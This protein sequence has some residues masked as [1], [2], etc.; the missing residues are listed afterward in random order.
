MADFAKAIAISACTIYMQDY[1]GP[2]GMRLITS[3]RIEV[4][5]II[6]QNVVM[7]EEGLPDTT[8]DEYAALA[9]PGKSRIQVDLLKDY[10]AKVV[11][12]PS[13]QYWLQKHRPRMLVICGK[14]DLSFTV[15]EALASKRDF[16]FSELELLNAGHLALDEAAPQ[17][18]EKIRGFLK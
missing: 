18:V 13:W 4:S 6:V 16:P 3:Q 7:H 15:A 17:I 10:W 1:G 8:T 14:Y 9:R 11:F 5:S 2:I 12:F